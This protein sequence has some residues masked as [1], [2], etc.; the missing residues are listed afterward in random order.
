MPTSRTDDHDLFIPVRTL[1]ALLVGTALLTAG[2]VLAS[3]SRINLLEAAI[4][5]SGG[6]TLTLSA[7]GF[8]SLLFRQR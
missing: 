7:L 4:L 1:T 3:Q 2:F 6:L 5:I 8:L